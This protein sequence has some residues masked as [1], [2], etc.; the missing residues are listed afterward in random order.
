MKNNVRSHFSSIK[1]LFCDHYSHH[2]TII[3]FPPFSHANYNFVHT[4]LT[5][6]LLF[7]VHHSH[8][9]TIIL[10]V[11]FSSPNILFAPFSPSQKYNFLRTVLTTKLLLCIPRSHSHSKTII[12]FL[13]THLFYAFYVFGKRLKKII[14]VLIIQIIITLTILII[15]LLFCAPRS[16]PQTIILWSP[17]SHPN[18]CFT[19]LFSITY[20]YSFFTPFCTYFTP[21]TNAPFSSPKLLFWLH[22]SHPTQVL[23]YS[24]RSH[25]QTIILWP[26]FSPPNCCFTRPF[27]VT[28]FYAFFTPFLRLFVLLL[29]LWQTHRSHHPNYYFDCTVL[30]PHKYYFIHSVLI[31]KL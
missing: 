10:L 20:F 26:P 22:R 16:H 29:L 15:K 3:L 28:Y 12:L 8:R 19:L 11:P 24:L 7:C 4:I 6:K 13:F 23:F 2:Q 18:Y 5:T 17:F 21:L 30:A 14:S 31:P 1:L 25:P 9:Q 27:S